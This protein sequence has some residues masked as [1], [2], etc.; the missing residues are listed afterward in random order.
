M[1]EWY[2]W[3][4][5]CYLTCAGSPVDVAVVVADALDSEDGVL[6]VGAVTF[7]RPGID[8]SCQH[9]PE[10]WHGLADWH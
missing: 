4:Q 3:Q 9:H 7:S 6:L 2:V 1:C 5:N 8:D 10:V